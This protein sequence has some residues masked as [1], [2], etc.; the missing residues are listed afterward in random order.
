[1]VRVLLVEDN[2]MFRETFKEH[3]GLRF[4]SM[5]I[6]E[7]KNGDEAMEKVNVS[8]PDLIFMDISLPGENGLQ[9]TQKIKKDFPKVSIA[10]LT[11]YD[12]PEYR[13]AGVQNGADGFFIKESVQW[14]EVEAFVKS[15]EQIS[16]GS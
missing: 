3:L 6:D 4:P 11:G 9:L 1:M 8:P 10:L 13:Q 12:L 16:S 5:L 7:A 14:D 2:Q 15:I